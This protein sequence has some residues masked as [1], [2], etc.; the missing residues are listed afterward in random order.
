MAM[1]R[2]PRPFP[3]ETGIALCPP[4]DW[5][6]DTCPSHLPWNTLPLRTS[7]HAC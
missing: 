4:E 2:F 7:L 1:E 6:Q 3:L 5:A